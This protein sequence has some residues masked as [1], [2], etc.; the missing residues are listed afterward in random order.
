MTE[1]LGAVVHGIFLFQ[2][3]VGIYG[4][5]GPYDIGVSLRM[6]KKLYKFIILGLNK[7]QERTL[8]CCILFSDSSVIYLPPNLI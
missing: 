3:I 1:Y 8:S 5:S 6:Q 2:N 7:G 4:F